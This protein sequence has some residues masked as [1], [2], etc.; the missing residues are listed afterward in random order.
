MPT[1]PAGSILRSSTTGPVPPTR[2]RPGEN[3]ATSPPTC[4]P[5]RSVAAQHLAPNPPPGP[6]RQD[7]RRGGHALPSGG[8]LS[9]GLPSPPRRT[10]QLR[11]RSSCSRCSCCAQPRRAGPTR[12]SLPWVTQTIRFCVRGAQRPMACTAPQAVHHAAVFPAPVLVPLVATVSVAAGRAARRGGLG[13]LGGSM[14][15]PGPGL[16]GGNEVWLM[17]AIYLPWPV[18]AGC[19]RSPSPGLPWRAGSLFAV[20]GDEGRPP[21]VGGWL[22]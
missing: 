4:R 5:G 18:P 8:R 13:R 11:S 3:C 22:S 21:T 6:P 12:H 20:G 17:P 7:T 9:S 15:L 16:G 2:P 10:Q 1:R 19:A 14:T